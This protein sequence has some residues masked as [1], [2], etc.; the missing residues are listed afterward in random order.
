M[1]I[2]TPLRSSACRMTGRAIL[3]DQVSMGVKKLYLFGLVHNY[4]KPASLADVSANGLKP[5]ASLF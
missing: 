5:D 4:T 1:A 3:V 2:W